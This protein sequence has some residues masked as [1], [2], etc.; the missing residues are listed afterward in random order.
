MYLTVGASEYKSKQFSGVSEESVAKVRWTSA[1]TVE[2]RAENGVKDV[3]KTVLQLT[4]GRK[5]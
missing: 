1:V 4:D 3:V 2:E 5:A